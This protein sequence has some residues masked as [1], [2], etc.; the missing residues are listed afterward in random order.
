[1]RRGSPT[2]SSTDTKLYEILGIDKT[3][4][5]AD[6]KKAF[7]KAALQHHPDRGG[8]ADTFKDVNRAYEVLSDPEKRKIYDQV[9]QRDR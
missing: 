8:N 7:R 2:A 3:A 5:D 6:V 1:M 4:A 9:R